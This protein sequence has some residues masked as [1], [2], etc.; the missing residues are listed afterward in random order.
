MRADANVNKR[1]YVTSIVTKHEF[2]GLV[3]DSSGGDGQRTCTCADVR[4]IEDS[5][6][7]QPSGKASDSDLS[8]GRE[9]K[10]M[11]GKQGKREGLR[12]HHER[13]VCHLFPIER[14]K[15]KKRKEATDVEFRVS[16]IKGDGRIH[17]RSL[18]M[19][20]KLIHSQLFIYR[21]IIGMSVKGRSA[22]GHMAFGS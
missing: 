7:G 22:V 3:W 17:H 19:S 4:N 12:K 8:K 14:G 9:K 5:L 21:L 1:R 2:R 16:E 20:Q 13:A 6:R 15:R 10:E 11:D 18:D